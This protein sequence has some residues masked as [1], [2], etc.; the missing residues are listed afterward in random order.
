MADCFSPSATLI[1]AWRW[2]SDSVMTARLVRSAVR[3]RFIESCTSGGGMSSRISTVVTLPPHRSVC[4]DNFT[5]STSL[6]WSRLLST[7]SSIMS[8]A[9]ARRVV[10]AMPWSAPWKSP[11]LT[12]LSMGSTIFQ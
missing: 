12:R 1:L 8:P 9:T 10:V 5:R 11:T 6:T 3:T 4:S 7:S 2:P